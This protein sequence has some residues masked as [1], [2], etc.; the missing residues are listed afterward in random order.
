MGGWLLALSLVGGY[1]RDVFGAGTDEYKRVLNASVLAAGLVGVGA[2]LAKF[3]LSRGFFLLSFMIGIPALIL[4]RF[5]LR[6]AR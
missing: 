4:G 2:Y 5:Q 1:S 3:P 6:P